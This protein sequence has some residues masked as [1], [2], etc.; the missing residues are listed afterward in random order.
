MYIVSTQLVSAAEHAMWELRAPSHDKM[1]E[2][3]QQIELA[4]EMAPNDGVEQRRRNE[5]K[6]KEMI[7]RSHAIISD[8]SHVDQRITELYIQR[9]KYR[10]QLCQVYHPV[11]DD[12]F[13]ESVDSRGYL[14][15]MLAAV[16]AAAGE[17]QSTF[18]GN[19]TEPNPTEV[20]R[21]KF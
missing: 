7:H 11:A 1:T 20:S 19:K 8:L 2:I 4:I 6:H 9:T 21:T 12:L 16:Q 5:Q 15:G 14:A 3:I 18:M 17:L 13:K 10:K